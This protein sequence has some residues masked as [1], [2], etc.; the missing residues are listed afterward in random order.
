MSREGGE[1]A[2]ARQPED[3]SVWWDVSPDGILSGNW[4]DARGAEGFASYGEVRMRSGKLIRV[5]VFG[6]E[7]LK[8]WRGHR[9]LFVSAE[10][11]IWKR[12]S[13]DICTQKI[14]F[15][16]VRDLR[17]GEG[18]GREGKERERRKFR[19]E[20]EAQEGRDRDEMCTERKGVDREATE[21][22]QMI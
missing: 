12:R 21:D 9:V 7:G 17:K 13:H 16:E 3:K 8:L 1:G 2:G 15:G 4:T 19:G 6:R 20:G 5:T 18:E 11:V 10:R 22:S 14:G